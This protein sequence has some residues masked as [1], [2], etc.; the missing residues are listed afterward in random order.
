MLSSAVGAK[1]VQGDVRALHPTPPGDSFIFVHNDVTR[2]NAV[3]ALFDTPLP[4]MV[5]SIMLSPMRALWK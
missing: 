1:V 4:H 3:V 5:V 2:Y